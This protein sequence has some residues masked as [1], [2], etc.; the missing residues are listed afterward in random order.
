MVAEEVSQLLFENKEDERR[1][2]ELPFGN[3]RLRREV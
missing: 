3:D 1:R 2:R